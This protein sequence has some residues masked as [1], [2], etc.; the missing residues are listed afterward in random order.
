MKKALKMYNLDWRRR[1][2]P[3]RMMYCYQSV[4]LQDEEGDEELTAFST[5]NKYTSYH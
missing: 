4:P 3:P 5:R 2:I 1:L